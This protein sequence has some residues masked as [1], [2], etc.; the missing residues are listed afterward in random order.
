ML[1]VRVLATKG[2]LLAEL[3]LCRK[4]DEERS[5]MFARSKGGCEFV[6]HVGPVIHE[7]HEPLLCEGSDLKGLHYGFWEV[8]IGLGSTLQY[9]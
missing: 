3:I 5:P 4:T 7:L 1:T 8:Y 6:K 2:P 9:W